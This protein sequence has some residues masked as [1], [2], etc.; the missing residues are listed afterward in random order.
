MIAAACLSAL[1]VGQGAD[2]LST[3]RLRAPY[4]EGNPL[5]LRSVPVAVTVKVAATTVLAVAG[6]RMRK[7]RPTLACGLF[8]VGAVSGSLGAWHNARLKR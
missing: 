2:T 8:L 5:V 7:T 1:L 6:W 4:R 3:M